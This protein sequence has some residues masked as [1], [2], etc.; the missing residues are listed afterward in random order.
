MAEVQKSQ[1]KMWGA[2]SWMSDELWELA[3]REDSSESEDEEQ[4]AGSEVSQEK[5]PYMDSLCSTKTT[6]H[7]DQSH[8]AFWHSVKSACNVLQ[9]F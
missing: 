4:E 5:N 7:S 2:I 8:T 6:P 9:D 1:D 3:T